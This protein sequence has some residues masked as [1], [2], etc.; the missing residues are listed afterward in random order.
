[1]SEVEEVGREGEKEVG[2]VGKEQET[3][4]EVCINGKR[5]S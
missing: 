2:K 3:V 4:G 5:E 1:M